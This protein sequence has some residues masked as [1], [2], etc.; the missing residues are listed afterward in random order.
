MIVKRLLLI[1]TLNRFFL[2]CLANGNRKKRIRRQNR[3]DAS[4]FVEKKMSKKLSIFRFGFF[5]Q[6]EKNWNKVETNVWISRLERKSPKND[7]K[8]CSTNSQKKFVDE[9]E[10]SDTT[11]KMFRFFLGEKFRFGNFQIEKR[12]R[13][14]TSDAKNV[15]RNVERQRKS[16]SIVSRTNSRRKT[17]KT[18]FFRRFQ[19]FV[20]STK[21]KLSI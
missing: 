9:E 13:R 3:S 5:L 17:K 10:K 4:R 12:I 18:V 14:F 21:T 15:E 6:L 20:F 16:N 2:V 11:S 19:R 1:S 8:I 7:K